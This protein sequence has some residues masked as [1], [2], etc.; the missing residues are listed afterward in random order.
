MTKSYF[1]SG[2][3]FLKNEGGCRDDVNYEEGYQ[4]EDA[5]ADV[6]LKVYKTSTFLLH[7]SHSPNY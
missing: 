4:K 5:S 2:K 3:S 6:N 1:T 7:T